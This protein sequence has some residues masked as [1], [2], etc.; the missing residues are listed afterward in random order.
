MT[1]YGHVL[2]ERT[3]NL[4]SLTS[5]FTCG[6][7][8]VLQR[9]TLFFSKQFMEQDSRA[10]SDSSGSYKDEAEKT[11]ATYEDLISLFTG[12]A[13]IE[14][15][16]RLAKALFDPEHPLSYLARRSSSDEA[17]KDKWPPED[18]PDSIRKLIDE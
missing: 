7:V 3:E 15:R 11:D 18:I 9:N 5:R 14:T 13:T 17:F 16:R 1:R 12:E 10:D 4:I 2:R 6:T 8:N